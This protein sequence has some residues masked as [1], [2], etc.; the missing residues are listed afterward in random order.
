ML[1]FDFPIVFVNFPDYF[2]GIWKMGIRVEVVRPIQLT[3]QWRMPT[4]M[5]SMIT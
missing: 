4:G 2:V 5:W 1:F 3:E